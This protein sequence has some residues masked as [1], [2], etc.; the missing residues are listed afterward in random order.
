MRSCSMV[1]PD[2]KI[3]MDTE[4]YCVGFKNHS[5]LAAK[6]DLLYKLLSSQVRFFKV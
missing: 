6:L 4:L 5:Q 2:T 3:L 1:I